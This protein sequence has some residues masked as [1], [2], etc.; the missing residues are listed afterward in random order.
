MNYLTHFNR[1]IVKIHLYGKERL[2]YNQVKEEGTDTAFETL[3]VVVYEANKRSV[4]Y[5]VI[6]HLL[7]L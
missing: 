3:A 1:D 2:A 5:E 6:R 4:H 7:R